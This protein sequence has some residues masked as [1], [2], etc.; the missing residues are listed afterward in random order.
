MSQENIADPARPQL[1]HAL[2]TIAKSGGSTTTKSSSGSFDENGWKFHPKGAVDPSRKQKGS[3]LFSTAAAAEDLTTNAL[4]P[5]SVERRSGKSASSNGS[6]PRDLTPTRIGGRTAEPDQ[7]LCGK[8]ELIGVQ[9][10]QSGASRT[11]NHPE[12]PSSHVTNNSERWS[13]S[14]RSFRRQEVEWDDLRACLRTKP[15]T[16]GRLERPSREG[17]RMPVSRSKQN[18]K[19]AHV[20][21]GRKNNV[22]EREVRNRLLHQRGKGNRRKAGLLPHPTL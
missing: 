9:H 10:H 6:L 13:K 4:S 14:T 19:S 7:P 15:T 16:L 22:D 20:E 17:Q 2:A 18:D 12:A 3:K 5:A 21:L 1:E 11:P 8:Q